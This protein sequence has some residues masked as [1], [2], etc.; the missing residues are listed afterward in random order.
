MFI[1]R[2]DALINYQNPIIELYTKMFHVRKIGKL[3]IN[4]MC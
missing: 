1:S 4:A 2:A 3:I